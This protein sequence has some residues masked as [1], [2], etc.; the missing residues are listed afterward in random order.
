MFDKALMLQEEIQCWSLLGLK[1]KRKWLRNGRDYSKCPLFFLADNEV[2]FDH[3]SV[4]QLEEDHS[5]VTD[6]IKDP[7]SRDFEQHYD[8]LHDI[9]QEKDIY[10]LR[11][12]K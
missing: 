11:V 2:L 7:T 6:G 4:D 10:R 12:S 3:D 9:D 8:M 1:G 5:L